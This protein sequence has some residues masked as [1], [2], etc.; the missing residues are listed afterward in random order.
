M[1]KHMLVF[2]DFLEVIYSQTFDWNVQTSWFLLVPANYI[3][4]VD[5]QRHSQCQR[6]SAQE[7]YDAVFICEVSLRDCPQMHGCFRRWGSH[8]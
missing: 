7:G 5:V 3:F 4:P 2:A 1:L 8:P 6:G